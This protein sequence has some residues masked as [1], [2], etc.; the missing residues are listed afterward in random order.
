[1][2]NGSCFIEVVGI[3]D[4]GVMYPVESIPI[5]IRNEPW[6]TRFTH[7][8]EYERMEAYNAKIDE[9]WQEV[10][11][12]LKGADYESGIY[13]DSNMITLESITRHYKVG[14]KGEYQA[15]AEKAFI[16]MTQ[17]QL[18]LARVCRTIKMLPR[19]SSLYKNVIREM[20]VSTPDGIA[21]RTELEALRQHA[22]LM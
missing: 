15:A 5:K 22:T 9:L 4:D 1:M 12:N 2:P 7:T 16:Q 13:L 11:A 3:G 20:G 21:A 8:D 10:R 14:K 6:E 19:A 18:K 17:Y